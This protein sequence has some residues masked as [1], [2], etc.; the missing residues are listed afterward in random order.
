MSPA[1]VRDGVASL[2]R[3]L[4]H[5]QVETR[6]IKRVEPEERIRERSLNYLQ[7]LLLWISVN[8]T[9]INITLG[10]LA[11]ALFKLSFKDGALCA[12]FGSLLGSIPTAYIAIWGPRSGNRSL[13]SC[14]PAENL[15]VVHA[16]CLQVFARFTMGWWPSKLIVILNIIICLGYS[17]IDLVVAGQ[18]LSAVSVNGRLSVVV[19][20]SLDGRSKSFLTWQRHYHHR[21]HFLADHDLWNSGFPRLS[22]VSWLGLMFPRIDS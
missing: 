12:A 8:L 20:G 7:A 3:G 17:L 14:P 15:H 11:P 10:M 18:I 4:N 16:H 19:G 5:L 9:A 22:K 21:H 13:V 6:G 1:T 2:E